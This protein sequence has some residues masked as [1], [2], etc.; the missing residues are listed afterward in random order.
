MN[1]IHHLNDEMTSDT[2]RLAIFE[3]K[4]F[5]HFANRYQSNIFAVIVHV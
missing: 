2:I 1:F 4:E 5:L 3:L